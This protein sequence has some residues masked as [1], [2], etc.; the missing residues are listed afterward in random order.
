MNECFFLI[1]I[2]NG[3][4]KLYDVFLYIANAECKVIKVL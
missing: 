1:L 4:F 3:S 2:L